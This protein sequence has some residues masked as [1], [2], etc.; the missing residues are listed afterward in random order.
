VSCETIYALIYRT[1]QQAEQLWRYLT[2]RHKRRRPRVTRF[3]LWSSWP[4]CGQC[5]DGVQ[6]VAFVRRSSDFA[7]L[8]ASGPKPGPKI[9]TWGRKIARAFGQWSRTQIGR[10]SCNQPGFLAKLASDD[11]GFRQR[12]ETEGEID[13]FGAEVLPGIAHRQADTQTR[14]LCEK[15]R[16]ARDHLAHAEAR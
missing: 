1:T 12:T 6:L 15:C 8:Q 9:T 5:T 13:P 2:R 10:R 4:W 11:R 3:C 7:K 14:V 16:Q